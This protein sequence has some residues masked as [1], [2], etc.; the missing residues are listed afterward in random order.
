MTKGSCLRKRDAG[1]IIEVPKQHAAARDILEIWHR[2]SGYAIVY[3]SRSLK[4]GSEVSRTQGRQ[5]L[6]AGQF[7]GALELVVD[8]EE[9]AV[10]GRTGLVEVDVCLVDDLYDRIITCLAIIG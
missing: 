3:L 8:K 4:L 6:N 9:N 2:D 5:G 1:Q 7:K 10:D